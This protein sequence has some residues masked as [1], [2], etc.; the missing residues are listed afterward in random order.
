[1]WIMCKVCVFSSTEIY[2]RRCVFRQFRRCMVGFLF[3]SG[4]ETLFFSS[5]KPS[6]F[7]TRA[8]LVLKPV[9]FVGILSPRCFT[10]KMRKVLL[11]KSGFLFA[12]ICE[13]EERLSTWCS[14]RHE[15]TL[16]SLYSTT[17]FYIPLFDTVF[18]IQRLFC[19]VFHVVKK[20]FFFFSTRSSATLASVLLSIN[21]IDAS[22]LQCVQNVVRCLSVW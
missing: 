1:M 9:N 2:V 22:W 16:R 20:S 3:V 21:Q 10:W 4:F 5:S 18:P 8:H 17:R 11:S 14:I 12:S 6:N 7:N 13:R 15:D 19:S